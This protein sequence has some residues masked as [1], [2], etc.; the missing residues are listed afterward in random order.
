[1]ISDQLFGDFDDLKSFDSSGHA[2]IVRRDRARRG[3]H[4]KLI[5]MNEAG[6]GVRRC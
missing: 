1:V 2:V 4:G 3:G 6:V 5:N